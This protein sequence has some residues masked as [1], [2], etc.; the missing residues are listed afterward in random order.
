MIIF[1]QYILHEVVANPAKYNMRRQFT[2]WRIT[3]FK[4]P[5][6]SL[7]LFDSQAVIPLPGGMIP[8]MYS[9]NHIMHWQENEFNLTPETRY[10]LSEWSEAT[11]RKRCLIKNKKGDPIVS[12]HME[13]LK[14]YKLPLYPPYLKSERKIYKGLS[15]G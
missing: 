8:P 3:P 2:G 10:N 13:S 6:Y 5:L 15:V 9:Q 11:F 12:R 4:R 14:E 1:P 7:D